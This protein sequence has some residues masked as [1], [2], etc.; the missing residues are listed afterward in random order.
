MYKIGFI[1]KKLNTYPRKT[2]LKQHYTMKIMRW[3]HALSCPNQDDK[4]R[5][6]TSI[7]F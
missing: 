5:L 4:F 7:F 2:Y 6:A 1:N 3:A